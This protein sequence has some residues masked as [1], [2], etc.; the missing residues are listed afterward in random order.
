M[1]LVVR[2]IDAE[3]SE[4][5]LPEHDG[6]APGGR[7]HLLRTDGLR[8]PDGLARIAFHNLVRC[9]RRVRGPGER[10]EVDA[11]VVRED[12]AGQV[13]LHHRKADARPRPC[14]DPHRAAVERQVGW[15]LGRRLEAHLVRMVAEQIR[16][17]DQLVAILIRE[18]DVEREL[19][20]FLGLDERQLGNPAVLPLHTVEIEILPDP[21]RASVWI[22]EVVAGDRRFDGLAAGHR[23]TKFR[24]IARHVPR[25]DRLL[26]RLVRLM[27]ADDLLDGDASMGGDVHRF[28]RH[29]RSRRVVVLERK[30]ERPGHRRH[31]D[32]ETPAFPAGIGHVLVARSV[33]APRARVGV[34]RERCDRRRG[35]IAAGNDDRAQ[36]FAANERERRFVDLVPFGVEH[37]DARGGIEGVLTDESAIETRQRREH[38]RRRRRARVHARGA[39]SER[40]GEIEENV[41]RLRRNDGPDFLGRIFF[42]GPCSR[43][44]HICRIGKE[45]VDVRLRAGFVEFRQGVG[46]RRWKDDARRGILSLRCD[47]K[48][49]DGVARDGRLDVIDGD[50]ERFERPVKARPVDDRLRVRLDVSHRILAGIDGVAEDHGHLRSD[51]GRNG[52]EGG[53]G[54]REIVLA[55][56]DQE[57][58][59]GA[60]DD[61]QVRDGPGAEG[62]L[63]R[64]FGRSE[65]EDGNLQSNRQSEEKC[66][67]FH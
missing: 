24:S 57:W 29:I 17:A 61:L 25:L 38:V 42:G 46:R 18:V 52:V 64:R 34:A 15:R 55:N 28:F 26:V 44:F 22:G 20:H 11:F 8:K 13:E 10:L 19:C 16:L 1:S 53:T 54:R 9:E 33:I 36:V 51:R 62:A 12:L 48:P 35:G 21:V 65:R 31:P 27:I 32:E 7:D 5:G 63:F 40:A 45:N 47:G 66:D 30:D 4:L 56:P 50:A 60:G 39:V 23:E 43:R 49:L 67:P 59:G 37:V 58:H 2:G 41:R 14:I 6:A 3:V